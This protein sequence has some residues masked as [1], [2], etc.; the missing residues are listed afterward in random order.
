MK[1]APCTR[2]LLL[3]CVWRGVFRLLQEFGVKGSVCQAPSGL[4]DRQHVVQWE[5]TRQEDAEG[6]LTLQSALRSAG[7]PGYVTVIIT[8]GRPGPAACQPLATLSCL[9]AVS[10]GVA[11]RCESVGDALQASNA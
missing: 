9:S 3:N 5:E 1:F 10:T 6:L 11:K 2:V 4:A 8:R 7:E